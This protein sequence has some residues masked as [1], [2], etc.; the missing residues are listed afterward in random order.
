MFKNLYE[1]LDNPAANVGGSIMMR[2]IDSYAFYQDLSEALKK[3]GYDIRSMHNVDD[4]KTVVEALLTSKGLNYG[5][6]PKGLLKFHAYN[7]GT[8]TATEEHFVEGLMY[9]KGA[10]KLQLHFTISV[11]HEQ[12]FN[13]EFDKLKAKYA[14]EV[15]LSVAYSFQKK[16]TD[17]VAVDINN[18]PITDKDGKFVFRPGGHG[19][20]L[21]NLNDIDADLI[22]IKNIDNVVPDH[23]K[24]VTVKYKKALAGLL[25]FV[26]TEINEYINYLEANTT[27][28]ESLKERIAT[29]MLTYLGITLP[30]GMDNSVFAAYVKSKLD[31][32]IRICGMVRNVGEPGGGPF[33]VLN[34]KR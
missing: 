28:S 17:T 5:N 25:V 31:K 9:A 32:P 22:F 6:L 13:A 11:E 15:E 16:S 34:K 26:K 19:A 10:N 3:L 18:V 30:K 1:F 23:L 7:D 2:S 8:R 27:I 24:H 20:L 4:T 14:K 33:W 29:F 12:L 21:E